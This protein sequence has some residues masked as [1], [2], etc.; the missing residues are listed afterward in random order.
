MY[1]WEKPK[2]L[3]YIEFMDGHVRVSVIR[4]NGKKEYFSVVDDGF[5]MNVETTMPDGTSL[6]FKVEGH[7]RTT[8]QRMTITELVSYVLTNYK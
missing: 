3:N 2:P 5:D 1:P 4:T 7:P 6:I 8:D